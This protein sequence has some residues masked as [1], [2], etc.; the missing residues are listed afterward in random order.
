[1]VL[2]PSEYFDAKQDCHAYKML[3]YITHG[4]KAPHQC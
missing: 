1:M 4:C 3:N 2:L